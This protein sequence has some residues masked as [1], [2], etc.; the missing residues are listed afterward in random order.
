MSMK[1]ILQL[2][3]Y[4]YLSSIYIIC[5]H[6]HYLHH[7]HHNHHHQHHHHRSCSMLYHSMSSRKINFIYSYSSK[8]LLLLLQH[9]HYKY[10]NQQYNNHYKVNNDRNKRRKSFISRSTSLSMIE[11]SIMDS[12]LSTII[13]KLP[14]INSVIIINVNNMMLSTATINVDIGD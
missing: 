13:E 4:L 11:S 1:C 3:I 6:H 9:Q 5:Y 14:L 12:S 8:S 7:N 2:V 10:N